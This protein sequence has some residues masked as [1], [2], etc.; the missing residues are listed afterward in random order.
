M[1]KKILIVGLGLAVSSSLA[2]ADPVIPRGDFVAKLAKAAGAPGQFINTKEKFP[3]D[4]F[5]VSNNLPFLAGLTLHHPM[6]SSLKLSKKQI[7]AITEIK[8]RTVPPIIKVSQDIKLLELKLAQNIA[9]DINSAKSQYELVDTISK[10][11]TDLTKAHLQCINEVRAVLSKEQYQK[12]LKY[13]T[14]LVKGK[15]KK[16][17]IDELV[18][19][20]HPGKSV[21][22]GKI[23]LTKEQK[24]KIAKEVKSV[25]API[26]QGKMREAFELEKKVQ[27]MVSKGKNKEE[28]KTILDKISK[29]K[30]EAIDS[31]IDALNHIQKIMTKEQW[32]KANKLTYK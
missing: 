27:R 10:L 22:M 14:N 16:F 9:I 24:E 12:M 3:K 7:K 11:R 8:K 15:N 20:P 1:I 31:R 6:S 32:K 17:K 18:I 13:A 21:K 5:L 23:S 2:F 19:L 4:Y 29:L 28:L 26:F 30:R 25:Y